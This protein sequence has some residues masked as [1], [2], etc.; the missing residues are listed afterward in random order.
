MV[1]LCDASNGDL[2]CPVPAG[3]VVPWQPTDA[4]LSEG[5]RDAGAFQGGTSIYLAGGTTPTADYDLQLWL[6]EGT[7]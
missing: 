6:L 1:N 3:A 5:R 7:A 4:A 2:P